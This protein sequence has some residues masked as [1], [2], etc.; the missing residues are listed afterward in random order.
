MDGVERHSGKPIP[1]PAAAQRQPAPVE[2]HSPTRKF[3]KPANARTPQGTERER[4]W[5]S[6]PALQA[7]EF[8]VRQF[9]GPVRS[10]PSVP[11]LLV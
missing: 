2:Q 11:L 9:G 6:T 3:A 1:E 10:A 4:S 7:S 5:V 8:S